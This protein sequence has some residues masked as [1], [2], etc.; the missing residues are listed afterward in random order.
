MSK[1]LDEEI[2]EL[3]KNLKETAKRVRE[4]PEFAK[5]VLINAGIYDEEGNLLPPY[6][7]DDTNV[8]YHR[9]KKY[10]EENVLKIN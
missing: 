4:N 2:A 5:Q 7:G 6:N 9:E 10:Y 1:S 3:S 8:G